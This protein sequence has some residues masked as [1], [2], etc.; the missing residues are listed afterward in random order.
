MDTKFWKHYKIFLA[1]S[2]SLIFIILALLWS[3]LSAYE[4]GLPEFFIQK[5][6]GWYQ[7]GDVNEIIK[8]INVDENSFN[9]KKAVK[10]ILKNELNSAKITYDKKTG[11]YSKDKPVYSILNNNEEI[12]V[13][14]L[15]ASHKKNLFHTKNWLIKNIDEKFSEKNISII[16]PQNADVFIND[17]KVTEEYL[18]ESNYY[19]ESLKDIEYYLSPFECLYEV[20]NVYDNS[21][22]KVNDQILEKDS[23]DFYYYVY[24][25]DNE[26]LQNQR[27]II[28]N[29][30]INYTK[31]V[32][33]E[34]GFGS[35]SGI[36]LP[37]SNAYNF[38]Q[39]VASTNIWLASHTPTE[40]SE[41]T[42]QNMQV[43][44]ESAYSVDVNF[45]Y[46]FYVGNDKKSY[47]TNLTLYF[48]N[49]N[50]M[51]LIANLTT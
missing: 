20:P 45:E 29:F 22:I 46:S 11:L 16:A 37:G 25:S 24:S 33:N 12:A 6:A 38:L 23:E 5:V 4:K 3:F 50:G 10:M 2:L 19:R 31:Y 36:V 42:F 18:K 41:I 27:E 13:V 51:W 39:G 43:Y 30:C 9:T 47:E 17:K 49:V 14:S 44:S 48:I 40:F 1:I 7:T 21:I 34:A 8:Y 32:V 15:K 26:L 28:K 35:I